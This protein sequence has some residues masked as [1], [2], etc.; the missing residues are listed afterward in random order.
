VND[1]QSATSNYDPP[2][3][4]TIRI[5]LSTDPDFTSKGWGRK[6]K[7]IDGWFNEAR[8]YATCRCVFV[9]TSPAGL[10]LAAQL[11]ALFPRK[12]REGTTVVLHNVTGAV[13]PPG[14]WPTPVTVGDVAPSADP[15][16]ALAAIL[17]TFKAYAVRWWETEGRR[18]AA[19]AEARKAANL[20]ARLAEAP[21]DLAAMV[22][23]VRGLGLSEAEVRGA[24]EVALLAYDE[25]AKR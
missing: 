9:P 14:G 3:V 20:A 4:E 5:D 16:Q 21:G 13:F 12:R 23:R 1:N 24:V 18:L 10:A 22:R 8:G 15:A 6:L 11:L 19:E 17:E 25:G 2:V 7:A